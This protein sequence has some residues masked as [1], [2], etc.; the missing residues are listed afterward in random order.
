MNMLNVIKKAFAIYMRIIKKA[1]A[2]YMQIIIMKKFLKKFAAFY[3]E[4]MTMYGESLLS[5]YNK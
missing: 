5:N 3:K 4:A 2:I 1:F